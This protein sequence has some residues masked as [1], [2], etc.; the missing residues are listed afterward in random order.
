M[1]RHRITYS[2]PAKAGF[3]IV[4]KTEVIMMGKP[5]ILLSSVTYA[6]KGRDLLSRQGI[7]AYVERIPPSNSSGCGYGLYVPH[8]ADQAQ[9]ILSENGIKILGRL[10]QEAAP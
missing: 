2:E 3:A 9:R 7:P 4:I 8:G 1:P 10:E 6:M 5:V